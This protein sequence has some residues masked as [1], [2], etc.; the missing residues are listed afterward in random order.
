MAIDLAS[1]VPAAGLIVE[2][3]L[4]SVPARGAEL[5]PFLP[6][7]WMA[8]NRFASVDKIARV[9]FPKLFVHAR[10]DADVPISHGRRLFELAVAPKYF[11]VW[12]A[13]TRPAITKVDRDSST[14]LFEGVA[15]GSDD[16]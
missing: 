9:T 3:S 15:T 1:R 8:H 6:V 4:L 14:A 16:P 12:R 5:Y 11:G 7:A 10:E 13:A 2:G